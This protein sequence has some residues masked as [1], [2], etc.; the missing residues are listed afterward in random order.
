MP[1][2][3][4]HVRLRAPLTQEQQERL[5][6][7]P[8]LRARAMRARPAIKAKPGVA[9][10]KFLIWQDTPGDRADWFREAFTD[11]NDLLGKD[12]FVPAGSGDRVDL[13]VGTKAF[14]FGMPQFESAPVGML[15]PHSTTSYA[16]PQDQ[17]G[18]C[19]LWWN[20]GFVRQVGQLWVAHD[21]NK[22]P[23]KW[24]LS[25]E[26]GH[27]ALLGHIGGPYLMNNSMNGV[28][29]PRKRELEM[30]REINGF[31]W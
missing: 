8:I 5:N 20:D 31:D 19:V 2:T 17:Y 11:W 18:E 25:H 24:A 21:L 3:A 7:R 4:D 9:Q 13:A 16:E 28:Y 26:I 14:P 15:L 6:G 12:V 10:Y 29:L 22:A 30:I 1:I 23:T 27:W